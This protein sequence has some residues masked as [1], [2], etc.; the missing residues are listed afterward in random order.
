MKDY[1]LTDLHFH[2]VMSYDAYEN[3]NNKNKYINFDLKEIFKNSKVGLLCI[4]DHNYFC[5]EKF[6]EFQKELQN[7][8]ILPAIEAT[9]DGLH[10]IFIFDEEQ[11]I[12][13]NQGKKL[14]DNIMGLTGNKMDDPISNFATVSFAAKDFIEKINELQ[15][16]YIAIPHLDKQKG[17]LFSG[18][19]TQEKYDL[20]QNY[21]YSNIIYGFEVKNHDQYFIKK[22]EKINKCIDEIENALEEKSKLNSL[23]G[24]L[25]TTEK[26]KKLNLPAIHGSDYHGEIEG[27]INLEEKLFYIKSE[28]TFEGLRLALLDSESRIYSKERLEK[29]SKKSAK[30][31]KKITFDIDGKEKDIELGDGLNSII[32]SRGSGK[33]YL[34]KTLLSNNKDYEGSPI[35]NQIKL[36]SFE[37]QNTKEKNTISFETDVDYI[38]QKS[39]DKKE[40]DTKMNN[41]YKI[42]A[43]APYDVENFMES[44][45]NMTSDKIE[46]LNLDNFFK[47][48]NIHIGNIILLN[49]V[50]SKSFDYSFLNT[51]SRFKESASEYYTINEFLK[52]YD[53]FCNG[54]LKKYK[55]EL[56]SIGVLKLSKKKFVE[57]LEKVKKI[58]G[59]EYQKTEALYEELKLIDKA[60]ENKEKSIN[61]NISRISNTKIIST[62]LGGDLTEHLSNDERIYDSKFVDLENRISSI[63]DNLIQTKESQ[64]IIED[65]L[66]T[67]VVNKTQ[68]KIENSAQSILVTAIEKIDFKNIS[69]EFTADMFANY[70]SN[71]EIESMLKMFAKNYGESFL[72]E[73]FPKKDKR[74]TTGENGGHCIFKPNLEVDVLINIYG[75]DQNLKKMS[76]GEKSDILLDLVLGFN[77]N[78]ILI[79]DQPEDDLDNE[80]IFT[81][82]VKKLREVKLNRQIIIVSHNANL[83]INGDSDKIIV[84]E[85]KDNQKYN[86]VSDN[87][88]SREKY[89][90]LSIDNFMEDTV[91][92]IAV[93]I[94]DGGKEALARRVKKVG[95]KDLFLRGENE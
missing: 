55:L 11:L 59:Y 91:L 24:Q 20:I 87:M 69:K 45:K 37:T 79:I 33:T 47:N 12:E 19:I 25:D 49:D 95:Y 57:D 15:L 27:Y 14:E 46:E 2:S 48:L 68:W 50:K 83:V 8:V 16:N 84:C 73:I 3:A 4:S 70:N 29:Y 62:I 40:T 63:I 66:N 39:V 56:E 31:V 9:I 17:L 44:I 86:I 61:N 21:L 74:K 78:K 34:I 92:N 52:R 22:I 41:F 23:I 88:E 94:L 72:E 38:S 76:P 18:K 60:N 54:Y 93:N 36:K 71:I 10:W 58:Q 51:Y 75:E 32:G 42:L 30:M 53:L 81:K 65:D 6:L 89:N 28:P 64:L 5:Y 13:N 35:H 43:D 82:V 7:C 26:L 90:Y 67:E 77:S 85:K 1:I 80:T